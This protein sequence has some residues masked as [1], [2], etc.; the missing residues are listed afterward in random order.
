MDFRASMHFFSNCGKFVSKSVQGEKAYKTFKRN[1]AIG[2]DGLSGNIIMDV[3]DSIKV[4]LFKIFKAS[5]EETV[6][7]KKPKSYSSF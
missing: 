5:F 4:I 3:Y 7:P 6:F 2:S 1:K